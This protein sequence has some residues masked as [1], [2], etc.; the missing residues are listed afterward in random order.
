MLIGKH[1]WGRQSGATFLWA[2]LLLFILTVGLGKFL[3]IQS[4]RMQR[5]QENELL[6]TGEQYRRAIERYYFA[7]PGELK[8]L[9]KE[10]E[11]LLLDPRLLTMTRHLREAYADPISQQP[12]IEIRDHSGHLIGVRSASNRQPL[13][14]ANF[15]P[16]HAH[17][18][19]AISYQQ[20]EFIF[21]P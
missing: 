4:T 11:H 16:L 3:E 13:K 6:W 14:Q 7:S 9:P 5:E 17:F 21:L 15:E 2:L 20:W 12:F 1:A 18:A 8:Q 19:N 10:V